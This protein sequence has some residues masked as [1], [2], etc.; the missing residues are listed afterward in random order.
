MHF[1]FKTL[2]QVVDSERCSAEEIERVAGQWKHWRVSTVQMGG[3]TAVFFFWGKCTTCFVCRASWG[4]DYLVGENTS[5]SLPRIFKKESLAKENA[6]LSA[7]LPYSH[8]RLGNRWCCVHNEA[9]EPS[10]KSRHILGTVRGESG[11]RQLLFSL[12]LKLMYTFCF[13][14]LKIGVPPSQSISWS[15]LTNRIVW[16]RP[17]CPGSWA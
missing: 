1:L 6:A 10:G 5:V 7:P 14:Y 15:K 17:L 11:G 16:Y 4:M 8:H 12:F 2:F 3:G 9:P 13:N